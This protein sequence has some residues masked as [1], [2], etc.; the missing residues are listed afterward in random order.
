MSLQVTVTRVND[1]ARLPVEALIVP[2]VSWEDFS[3][4]RHEILRE[5]IGDTYHRMLA[6]LVRYGLHAEL[7][8]I[9]LKDKPTDRHGDSSLRYV[10]FVFMD[11]H[12]DAPYVAYRGALQLLHDEGVETVALELPIGVKTRRSYGMDLLYLRF[13]LNIYRQITCRKSRQHLVLV[14]DCAEAERMAQYRLGDLQSINT[15]LHVLAS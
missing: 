12:L 3:S 15:K 10:A 11:A 2:I 14:V 6:S 5:K 9:L 1:I 7:P 13:M 8:V 4:T